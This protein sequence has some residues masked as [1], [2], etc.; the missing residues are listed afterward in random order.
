MFLG[1]QAVIAKSY[2][3]IHK[4]NLINNG[5]L[6]L[7]FLND[8]DYDSV[9]LLDELEIV[10]VQNLEAAKNLTVR[11]RTSG[12]VFTAANDL[13]EEQVH[14]IRCGGLLNAIRKDGRI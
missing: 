14:L 3:R 7:R 5:I 12:T 8:A 1:I 9:S 4:Q 10:D 6:P 11:N 13:T 2:A